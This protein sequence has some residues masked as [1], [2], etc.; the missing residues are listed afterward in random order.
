VDDDPR[1]II[2][3]FWLAEVKELRARLDRGRL[4][5]NLGPITNKE[6]ARATGIPQSTLSD[7]L[8]CKRDVVPDW[9]RVGLIVD[10]LGGTTRE[11]VPKW[12]AARAA[13]DRL[14][15]PSPPEP[16]KNKRRPRIILALVGGAAVL[17]VGVWIAVSMLTKPNPD[18]VQP[19]TGVVGIRCVKVKDETHTVSVFKDPASHDRWTE[20]PGGT[21]FWS[22]GDTTDPNRYRVPLSNGRYGYITRDSKYVAPASGCP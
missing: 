20:W 6:I 13:Y 12:R 3:A 1:V 15:K 17:A 5:E 4:E 14:D 21:R 10:R 16:P 11:W 18:S 22:D 7:L 8:K 2:R 19:A 9:D